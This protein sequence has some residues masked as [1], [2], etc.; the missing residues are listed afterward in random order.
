MKKSL[1]IFILITIAIIAIR[2]MRFLYQ[3]LDWAIEYC[4]DMVL[5]KFFAWSLDK[6]SWPYTDVLTYNLPMTIYINWFALKIFGNSSFGFRLF[7]VTWL[8]LFSGTTF[9]YLNRKIPTLF[10]FFGATLCLTLEENATNFGALQRETMMLP[11]WILS[12][13]SYDKIREGKSRI[14]HGFLIG[15][16][17]LITVLIKPTAII[18]LGCILL[19][20]FIIDLKER[21][22]SIKENLTFYIS[23]FLGSLI[24]LFMTLLPFLYKGIMFVAFD[25]WLSYFRDLSLSLEIISPSQLLLNIFTFSFS[26]WFI[27][28]NEP[29]FEFQNNGHLSLFHLSIILF[30]LFLLFRG[31]VDIGPLFILITGLLNYLIQAKGFAYHLFPMWFACVLI[32]TFLINYLFQIALNN[33][34]G[35]KIIA[36]FVIFLVCITL[37]FQQARSLRLYKGTNLY[38]EWNQSKKDFPKTETLEAIKSLNQS[39][40]N[41]PTKIQIFEAYHSVS[42]SAIMN[43]DMILASR[44]PEAYVFYNEHPAM[45]KYKKDMMQ[46]LQ[47][48]KPDI[49]VLNRE[50]TFRVKKDLFQTFPELGDFLKNYTLEKEIK[51]INNVNYDLYVLNESGKT[52]K[53]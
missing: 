24:I 40:K 7:D 10:A 19:S 28:L 6:G 23:I 37:I 14:K 38:Y 4:V 41:R 46:S 42:L 35:K 36:S 31:K 3:S 11:F 20:L 45:D 43:Q 26:H 44:Y 16:Y 51:E 18:L 34:S 15:I 13:I 33:E 30:Y 53:K 50:G 9:V 1:S 8:I 48:N 22:V 27:P 2:S 29:I 17:I 12:L 32:V 5:M 52:E 47:K 21:K 39:V 25:Q 49:I